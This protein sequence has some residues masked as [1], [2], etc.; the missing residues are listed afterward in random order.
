MLHQCF[1]ICHDFV[2]V[3]N[4]CRHFTFLKIKDIMNYSP[5]P[6]RS[7]RVISI[8]ASCFCQYEYSLVYGSELRC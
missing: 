2:V 7:R 3:I 6:V 4:N 8:K 1:G 5:T